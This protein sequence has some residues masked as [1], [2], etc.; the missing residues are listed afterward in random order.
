[1]QINQASTRLE[2]KPGLF[3]SSII[4][5]WKN[6]PWYT[7][8]REIKDPIPAFRSLLAHPWRM[9]ATLSLSTLDP[10]DLHLFDSLAR[11]RGL[12]TVWRLFHL[13]RK[14]FLLSKPFLLTYLRSLPLFSRSALVAL[15]ADL[16]FKTAHLFN[17]GMVIYI[18]CVVRESCKT[19]CHAT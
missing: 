7:I 17:N 11:C 13:W 8:P 14:L 1:M 5:L 18:I 19:S 4:F 2:Y 3:Y 10:E 15:K 12:V 16:H 6:S 9:F